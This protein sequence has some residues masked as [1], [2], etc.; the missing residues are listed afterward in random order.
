MLAREDAP[1]IEEE[2]FVCWDA[3]SATV[4]AS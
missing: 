2:V 1:G 3:D 4:L